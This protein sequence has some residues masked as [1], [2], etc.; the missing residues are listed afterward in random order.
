MNCCSCLLE[1]NQDNTICE[2]LQYITSLLFTSSK[3]LFRYWNSFAPK[4]AAN[5]SSRGS[6][7]VFQGATLVLAIRNAAFIPLSADNP[8]K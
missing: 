2:S 8:L 5:S 3:V 1:D 4:G 6:V 7:V